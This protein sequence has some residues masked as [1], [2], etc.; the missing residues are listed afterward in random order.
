MHASIQVHVTDL[1]P[2]ARGT[3]TS[4][5]SCFFYLGQAVGPVVY[6]FG[7]AHGGGPEPTLL[8]GAVVL[9]AVSLVCARLLRH[10]TV[11]HTASR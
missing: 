8:V 6:A 7:F 3:A 11:V 4:L 9:V 1:S 2:T 10:R 5:H